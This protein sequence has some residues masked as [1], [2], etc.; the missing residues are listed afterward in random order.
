MLDVV[1]SADAPTRREQVVS[2]VTSGLK[3]S[4]AVAIAAVDGLTASG[5][6]SAGDDTF[7]T[8]QGAVLQRTIRGEIEAITA[9]LYGD[10]PADDLATAGRVLTTITERANAMLAG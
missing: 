3:V 2:R 5:I 7:L 4:D 10:L 9:R 8:E 6:V 1:A